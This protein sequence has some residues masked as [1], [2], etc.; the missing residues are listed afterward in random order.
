MSDNISTQAILFAINSA[1][2]LGKNI[3]RA[4]ANSLKSRQV[5]L[6]LPS[7]D[8]TPNAFTINRFFET[9][10]ARFVEEIEALKF[11]HRKNQIESL[12]RKE[13]SEYLEYYRNLFF[14]VAVGESDED[15]KNSGLRTEDVV[16]LLKIRQWEQNPKFATTTLQLV[17]GAIVEIGIDYF[18]QVPG[19]VRTDSTLGKA[20]AHLLRA[21]DT[22]PFSEEENF[23][24]AISQK[25]IPRLFI[26]VTETLQELP[27]DVIRDEKLRLFVEA[28]S[29]GI[30]EDLYEKIGPEMTGAESDEAI[31]W[32]QMI[33]SSMIRN[34]GEYV[35]SS[36]SRL[37]DLNRGQEQLI[38]STGLTLLELLYAEDELELD[39][40]KVLHHQA[41]ELIVK[42]TFFIFSENPQ[43]LA[44]DDRL[45][46][47][48]RDVC[49]AI[50]QSPA[51]LDDI[52]PAILRI[53]L[54]KTALHLEVLWKQDEEEPE[55]LLVTA[56]QQLLLVLSERE[57][58]T[59][60]LSG[61]Q[62]L[63]IAGVLFEE[64]LRHP[65]WINRHLEDKPL[66][67]HMLKATFA[68]LDRLPPEERIHFDVLEL[69]LEINVRLIAT[70]PALLE[71]IQLGE[72]EDEKVLI[73]QILDLVFDCI[74]RE[75]NRANSPLE[76]QERLQAILS[77][78]IEV[79]LSR[80]PDRRGLLLVEYLLSHDKGLDLGRDEEL[81]DQ[82]T[83]VLLEFL[84][85]YPD[86]LIEDEDIRS[87]VKEFIAILNEYDLVRWETFSELIILLLER[88]A[89]HL[90]QIVI[91]EEEQPR[92]L[93]TMASREILG[94]LTQKQE[95]HRNLKLNKGQFISL[96]QLLFNEVLN[97][98][99]WITQDG[100]EQPA[101]RS[102]WRQLRCFVQNSHQ[103]AFFL[104]YLVRSF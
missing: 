8:S 1:L 26:A 67:Q 91:I 48:I 47:I 12:S 44:K 62:L 81:L 73:E 25:I 93:V 96:F 90:E 50:S 61:R 84:E 24:K 95:E 85:K 57:S 14:I 46:I 78:I 31:H 28:T 49:L 53:I 27:R 37:L 21:L 100:P 36:P 71:K 13:M 45:R 22:I 5:V 86:W 72:D 63:E 65:N 74:F 94:S 88:L 41:L 18:N 104:R 4:Y 2:R 3:Q 17:A 19:A 52:L 39:L 75:D 87:V 69:L 68:A 99:E 9:D 80:Y 77:Y 58:G 10:G 79:V 59:F 6:P 20:L 98:P 30:S 33:L 40:K 103:R 54:E 82:V 29:R 11:L 23:K 70:H 56:L 51:P 35:F 55:H 42:N 97:H 64:I 76:K 43:L 101:I 34:A 32:G 83:Q 15:I 102:H 60:Q 7:F 38:K 16:S 66:L 89:D 92:Y